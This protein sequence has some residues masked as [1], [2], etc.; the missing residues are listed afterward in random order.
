MRN[1]GF[2]G[3]VAGCIL[4]RMN[5][6][7]ME[8]VLVTGA[9]GFIGSHMVEQ[10]LKRGRRVLALDNLSTGALEN[11]APW[12]GRIEFIRGSVA[13]EPV[14]QDLVCRADAVIHLAAS[15][16][17]RVV[18]RKPLEAIENNLR[19]TSALLAACAKYLRPVV[20]ASSSEVYGRCPHLPFSEDAD[21]VLGKSTSPR[22]LYAISKLTNEFEAMA[23]ARQ[24][25]L[26]VIVTRFFNIAG[27]RQSGRFGMVLPRFMRQAMLG[28]TI[29]VYGDG[30]QVRC[31]CH[32]ESLCNAILDL[33]QTPAAYGE[34]IN[35]GSE[36]PVTV[37][38][39]AER[40]KARTGSSSDISLQPFAAVY[41]KDYDDM[42]RRQPDTSK[43]RALVGF[44]PPHS[45]DEIIDDIAVW[46]R[47]T[48]DRIRLERD[49]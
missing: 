21:L 9:A 28:E 23:Y 31:Y 43:A 41:G 5:E 16:G 17:N 4:C 32:V 47:A 1:S 6:R 8:T 10:L 2:S 29:T 35:L 27:P 12:L 25:G 3:R 18:S 19:G 40:V 11:L 33:M 45:L 49:Y 14:V 36:K 7:Q 30:Q 42:L 37:L 20:I 44:A 13:D 22:W 48:W 34:I 15:V 26:P 39:L 38:E 46:M 24:C